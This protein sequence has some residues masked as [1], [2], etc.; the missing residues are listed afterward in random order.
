MFRF[1]LIS[2][3]WIG[4]SGCLKD[5]RCPDMKFERLT[6][7]DKIVITDNMSREL[8]SI[9]DRAKIEEITDFALSHS[10]GWKVP[11]TGT[12][13]AMVQANFYVGE[14]LVGDL[15]VGGDFLTAHG[16]GYFQS[17]SVSKKDRKTIMS[18]LE[19]E[20]LYVGN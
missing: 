4:L 11:W 14:K 19:V 18:L 6:Q 20:G 16:C 10:S 12:P 17:R 2:I 8:R 15:G 13:V 7:T 9:N 1:L 3:C 5:A